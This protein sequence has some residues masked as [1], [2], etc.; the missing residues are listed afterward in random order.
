MKRICFVIWV[1]ICANSYG[2]YWPS[3]EYQGPW[4]M[5]RDIPAN[6]KCREA[7]IVAGGVPG[8]ELEKLQL[9]SMAGGRRD[10]GY[11]EFQGRL[12]VDSLGV[13]TTKV[14]WPPDLMD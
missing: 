2:Q 14:D 1:T 12:M 3:F 6:T 4:V 7:W 10:L 8:A 5:V 11:F 9:N 13:R